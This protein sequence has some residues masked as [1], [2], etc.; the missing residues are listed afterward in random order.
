MGVKLDYSSFKSKQELKGQQKDIACKCWFTSSGKIMP[1]MIKI[2]NEYGEIQT[3]DDITIC[4][5]EEK[6]YCGIT[7]IVYRCYLNIRNKKIPTKIIYNKESSKWS[8]IVD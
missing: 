6:K 8:I 3:I 2:E 4:S 1:L 5:S 7:N